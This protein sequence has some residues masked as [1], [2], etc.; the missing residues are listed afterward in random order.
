MAETEA[1]MFDLVDALVTLY[2]EGIPVFPGRSIV[3]SK[4]LY[5]IA[6]AFPSAISNEINDAR[7]ILKKKDEILHL[8]LHRLL[9]RPPLL[10]P[11]RR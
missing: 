2:E 3:D 5:S 4:K 6:N 10:L 8:R 1:K 11:V 7:I 9:Q